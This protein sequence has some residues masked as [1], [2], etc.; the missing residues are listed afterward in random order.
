[1]GES[2]RLSG[3][4]GGVNKDKGLQNLKFSSVLLVA[5]GCAVVISWAN[6]PSAPS[7]PMPVSRLI[8]QYR[9]GAF[10]LLSSTALTKI[11]P[12]SDQ[13]P[14]SPLPPSGFWFE[15]QSPQGALLY[16]RII[17]NP[18]TIY[19]EVPNPETGSGPERVEVPTADTV[20]SV[21]IPDIAGTNQLVLFSSP[22]GPAGKSQP[23]T[24]VARIAIV[25]RVK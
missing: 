14:P 2:K 19:T 24:V 1:M 11:I 12:P 17:S 25:S 7:Q 10:T 13:L 3:L 5:L 9:G 21:L 8:I 4:R 15:L 22:P 16:R 6:T 20:F 23:A 18:T